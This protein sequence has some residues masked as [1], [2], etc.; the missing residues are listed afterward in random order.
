MLWEH[1]I[2]LAPTLND[3]VQLGVGRTLQT[4]LHSEIPIVKHRTQ[5]AKELLALLA[6]QS[7]RCKRQMPKLL[8]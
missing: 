4:R 8:I 6:A 5:P 1:K 3:A 7:V 2:L